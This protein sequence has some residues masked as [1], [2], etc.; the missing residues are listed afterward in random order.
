MNQVVNDLKM[1][2]KSCFG[3]DLNLKGIFFFFFSRLKTHVPMCRPFCKKNNWPHIGPPQNRFRNTP[4]VSVEYFNFSEKTDNFVG[5]V[6][7]CWLPDRI[8][9]S[10]WGQRLSPNQCFVQKRLAC[11]KWIQY[12]WTPAFPWIHL[13]ILDSFLQSLLKPDFS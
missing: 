8:S 3:L 11:W 5:L 4:H 10:W 7:K 9:F 12:Q 2:N 13:H 1:G 6:N